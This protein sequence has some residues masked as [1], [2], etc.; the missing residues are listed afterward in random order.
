MEKE[1]KVILEEIKSVE[2]TPDDYIHELFTSTV[3]PDNSLGR[4]ILGTTE[5]IK[6]LNHERHHFLHRELLQPKEIVISVAGNF[7]HSPA[8]RTVE[9]QFR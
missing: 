4:P 9:H 1:R 8:D 7:E 5:T 2:D 3:W 6:A